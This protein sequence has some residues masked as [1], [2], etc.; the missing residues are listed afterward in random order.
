MCN[1]TSTPPIPCL[2]RASQVFALAHSR[3]LPD[4]S[5]EPGHSHSIPN[6]P[7]LSHIE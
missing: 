4:F 6:L 3:S 1:L 5:L 2:L 7:D